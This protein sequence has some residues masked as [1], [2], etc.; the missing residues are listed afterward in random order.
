MK[1][2]RNLSGRR[3]EALGCPKGSICFNNQPLD[4]LIGHLANRRVFMKKFMKPLGR[5]KG[6]LDQSKGSEHNQ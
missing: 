2:I 4:G 5:P 1:S 3:K 6:A